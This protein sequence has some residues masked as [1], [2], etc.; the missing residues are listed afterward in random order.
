MNEM[1]KLA[2]AA[3]VA[4]AGAAAS[5]QGDVAFVLGV[6]TMVAAGFTAVAIIVGAAVATRHSRPV[7]ESGR[8]PQVDATPVISPLQKQ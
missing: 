1:T 3:A 7:L 2:G 8:A 5:F 6:T 4:V